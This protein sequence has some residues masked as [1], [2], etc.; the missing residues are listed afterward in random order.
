MTRLL[1]IPDELVG[2]KIKIFCTL[3]PAS[4]NPDVIERLESRGV[5]LFRINL[6]HTAP[7]EVEGVIDLIRRHA[8]TRICLDTQGPQ[9]RSGKM[10]RDVVLVRGTKI[11]LT[12][13]PVAGTA[14]LVPLT[15]ASVFELLEP[16]SKVMI[17]FDA[18][19]VEVTAIRDNNASAVVVDGGRVRSAKAVTVER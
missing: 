9:V 12:A 8:S 6:S 14:T 5:D 7:E 18:A 17:D 1:A 10:T 15:P 4:L 2:G 3:G 13:E 11:T 16:G 19:T